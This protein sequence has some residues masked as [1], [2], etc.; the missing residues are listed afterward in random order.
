MKNNR[1][2]ADMIKT[3]ESHNVSMTQREQGIPKYLKR[4][5]SFRNITRQ[6]ETNVTLDNA[7]SQVEMLYILVNKNH[8]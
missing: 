8:E 6:A 5:Q 4:W 2:F 3:F 1:P 7:L